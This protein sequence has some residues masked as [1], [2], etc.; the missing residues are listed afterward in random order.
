MENSRYSKAL[1]KVWREGRVKVMSKEDSVS[2]NS[3]LVSDICKI[4]KK[5]DRLHRRA[6]AHVRK[7]E[8]GY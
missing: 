4:R 8:I 3:A 7:I 5:F 1:R 2:L 6:V